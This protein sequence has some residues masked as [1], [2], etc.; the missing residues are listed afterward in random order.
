MVFSSL[1]LPLSR[2]VCHLTLF[3]WNYLF[4]SWSDSISPFP[5]IPPYVV[6]THS[7]G[8][9]ADGDTY[10]AAV[11]DD[12]D[13]GDGDGDDGD[14]VVMMIDDGDDDVVMMMTLMMMMMV[15]MLVVMMMV[16]MMVVMMLMMKV[17]MM[18]W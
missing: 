15:M 12:S 6:K 4:L 17:M 7:S 14:D 5:G 1:E 16:M 3:G 13:D 11:H 9:N 2:P 8:R 18:M 10:T